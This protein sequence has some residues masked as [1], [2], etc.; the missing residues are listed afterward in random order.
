[1][2]K[3]SREATLH[4]LLQGMWKGIQEA[5][6]DPLVQEKYPRGLDFI[7]RMVTDLGKKA[8]RDPNFRLSQKQVRKLNQFLGGSSGVLSAV[9]RRHVVR[10]CTGNQCTMVSPNDFRFEYVEP[11][12]PTYHITGALTSSDTM[13]GDEIVRIDQTVEKLGEVLDELKGAFQMVRSYPDREWSFNR[14]AIIYK[15]SHTNPRDVFDVNSLTKTLELK[16]NGNP[17]TE[18]F[19]RKVM[20]YLGAGR[21]GI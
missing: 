12:V 20:K 7:E 2:R 16:I 21:G 18:Q 10:H 9:L 15:Q 14:G 1:M 8:K 6:Q 3:L 11:V 17:L 13:G 4:L 19:A 5:K